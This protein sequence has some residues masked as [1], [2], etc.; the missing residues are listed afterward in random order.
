MCRLARQFLAKYLALSTHCRQ[1]LKPAVR[2]TM[3]RK[4]F[5]IGLNKTGTKTLGECFGILGMTRD[6]CRPDLLA[7][8]RAGNLAQV[9]QE[10]DRRE[11]FEDWP[12]PLL[13]KELLFRYGSDARFILTRR[14][15]AA[16]W[17]NSLK[18][19][20][21]RTNPTRHCRLLA[22]G[23]A[24]PHGVEAHH[25]AFYARHETEVRQFF[26][27]Q[28]AG[29]QLLDICW[30]DGNGWTELCAFLEL[31][32]PDQPFPHTNKADVSL[33]DGEILKRNLEQINRQLLLLNP[34]LPAENLPPVDIG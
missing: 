3:A 21:L 31:P 12:Y 25:L 30:E 27:Q 11:A 23:Y 18:R 4:I 34:H 7:E 1:D 19:H 5:G 16:T 6:S 20:S 2:Q 26:V 14:R 28:G 13:Y 33:V 9:F 15:D 8:Y 32:V 17:L 24:Y 10:I 22:Y 29:R